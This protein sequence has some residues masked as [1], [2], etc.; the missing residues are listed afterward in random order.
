MLKQNN[1]LKR[2]GG[3]LVGGRGRDGGGALLNT[4]DFLKRRLVP[5][6]LYKRGTIV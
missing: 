6:G 5:R 4:A 2:F 1:E 3:V